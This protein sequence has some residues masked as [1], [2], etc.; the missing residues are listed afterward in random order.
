M[1]RTAAAKPNLARRLMMMGSALLVGA[2]LMAGAGEASANSRVHFSVSVGSPGYYPGYHQVYQPAYGY[3]YP[4]PR[5]VHRR[6]APLVCDAWGYCTRV[7]HVAPVAYAPAYYGAPVIVHER[8]RH[9]KRRH[10]HH[11]HHYHY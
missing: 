7:R 6:R 9:Y 5:V 8:P 11:H 2:A 3:G 1:N 4:P 10:H